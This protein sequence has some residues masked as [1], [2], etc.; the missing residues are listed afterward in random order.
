[1]AMV[2]L[3]FKHL[4]SLSNDNQLMLHSKL[5][6]VDLSRSRIADI[7]Y[8]DYG[9]QRRT[10]FYFQHIEKLL[11]QKKINWTYN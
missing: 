8:S 5:D 10:A 6:D 4:L 11:L 7:T 9:N 2:G 1:V 3:Y